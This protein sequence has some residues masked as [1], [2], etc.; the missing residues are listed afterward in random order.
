MNCGQLSEYDSMI[1]DEE[2]AKLRAQLAKRHCQRAH[3][4]DNDDA[5]STSEPL[6]PRENRRG[7]TP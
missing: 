7:R 4:D 3:S 1:V 5:V 6:Q 2:I